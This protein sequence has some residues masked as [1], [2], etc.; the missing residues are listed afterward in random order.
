MDEI[1]LKYEPRLSIKTFSVK[2]LERDE[3]TQ[4]GLIE[5]QGGD[6]IERVKSAS[7]GPSNKEQVI[8]ARY[9][10]VLFFTVELQFLRK[11]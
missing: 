2:A 11:D 5:V 6:I 3:L 1:R 10:F 4:K 7:S 8:A 9:F